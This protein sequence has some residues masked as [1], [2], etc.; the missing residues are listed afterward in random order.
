MCPC[1]YI[2]IRGHT[3]LSS[4]FTSLDVVIFLDIPQSF[5][6]E[7]HLQNGL[8]GTYIHAFNVVIHIRDTLYDCLLTQHHP[9]P[10]DTSLYGDAQVKNQQMWCYQEINHSLPVNY[11]VSS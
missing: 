11:P 9:P 10:A 4:V 8:L 6:I 7:Y 2:R 1:P 3:Y 5:V